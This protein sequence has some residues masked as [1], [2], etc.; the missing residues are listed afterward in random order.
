MS[1]IIKSKNFVIAL[2]AS[3]FLTISCG[4]LEK[5]VIV[6]SYEID[7][8]ILRDTLIKAQDYRVI[9]IKSDNS[10]QLKYLEGENSVIIGKWEILKSDKNEAF[11]R[12][13][14]S[15]KHIDGV[16]KGTIL[17]F[18]YPND[19]HSGKYENILYVK[20]KKRIN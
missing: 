11:I 15:D 16:L 13:N 3:F 9:S 8:C 20:L 12:F 6:G 19:F 10:F 4:K 2:T 18:D 7:K 5:E 1:K 17:N 14:Y